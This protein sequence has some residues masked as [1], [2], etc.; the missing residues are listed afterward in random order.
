MPRKNIRYSEESAICEPTPVE[1]IFSERILRN[2]GTR[3]SRKVIIPWV[4]PGTVRARHPS[5][6]SYDVS[7]GW[8]NKNE[9]NTENK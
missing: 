2:E 3:D 8:Q 4:A 7:H 6:A 5:K 1:I 9:K